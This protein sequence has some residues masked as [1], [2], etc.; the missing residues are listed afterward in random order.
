MYCIVGLGNPGEEYADT[1]HNVGFR[2]VD[3]LAK[4]RDTHIRRPEYRALTAT[5]RL[6]RT[7]VLVMK[8]QTYMNR[9]GVSV[10]AALTDNELAPRDLL[11]VYDDVD[12]P[13][14][15]VRVR[16]DGGS[17][18]HNGIQSIIDEL[19]DPSFARLRLGV[20]RPQSE[21]DMIDYVLASFSEEEAEGVRLLVER[22]VDAATVFVA[23]GVTVA[24]QKFN[25][26]PPATT[27][28]DSSE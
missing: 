5:V 13:L 2:V 22:G 18:G 8:P 4:S 28:H 3:Q 15:R 10:A 27:P 6:G 20:G 17:G 7:E 25:G 12:L 24:M 26:L 9:S 11:V 19:G 1:R 21:G 16:A 23:D 14:G